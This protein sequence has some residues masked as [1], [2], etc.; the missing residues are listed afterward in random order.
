MS[1]KTTPGSVEDPDLFLQIDDLE[2]ST[3]ALV[4][5]LAL[6]SHRS[7]HTGSGA[8]FE[9]H[10]DYQRGDDLRLINWR[11]HARTRRHYV[12]DFRAETNM[13]VH[14]VVDG[15]ASMRT[16]TPFSKH[17]WAVRAAAAV[18]WLA[19]QSRNAAGGG[20]ATNGIVQWLPARQT[21]TQFH[22]LI[23][24]LDSHPPA[25]TGSLALALDELGEV[26][27]RR[28]VVLVCSDFVDDTTA[29]LT[30][31]EGLVHQQHEVLALQI[32]SPEEAC[33]PA[34]GEYLLTD[35]ETGRASRASLDVT[36]DLYNAAVGQ[37]LAEM[38]RE[39]TAAGLSWLSVT[40]QTPLAAAL[41][42]IIQQ[43][44]HF[45]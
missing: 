5:S 26:C 2:L 33:L 15:S 24:L 44:V 22:D 9:R 13:P 30:A 18:A 34:E 7:H 38:A 27:R 23:G 14:V 12:R 32:L 45:R 36:R 3:R 37:W 40:T 25:G 43:S 39:A 42:E 19:L 6:G 1:G 4:D 31:L 8:E 17:A 21:T 10:R 35:P 20:I 11:L 41:R 29:V 16:G 28:G